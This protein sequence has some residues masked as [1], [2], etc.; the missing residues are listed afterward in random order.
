MADTA[1]L[2]A[3]A[4]A[5][6]NRAE[7]ERDEALAEVERLRQ[8]INRE[9]KSKTISVEF[10]TPENGG[11]IYVTAPWATSEKDLARELVSVLNLWIATVQALAESELGKALPETTAGIKLMLDDAQ[12]F[13][14]PVQNPDVQNQ[15]AERPEPDYHEKCCK[16]IRGTGCSDC[17]TTYSNFAPNIITLLAER[18]ERFTPDD[19]YFHPCPPDGVH[20]E[21]M[22]D[23]VIWVRAGEAQFNFMRGTKGRVIWNV[24]A[25][26]ESEVVESA[27]PGDATLGDP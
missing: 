8:H 25:G 24:H 21:R 23:G 9:A 22:D 7:R 19:E 5:G 20:I 13:P 15:L 1:R 3:A 14:P 17:D 12:Q 11:R 2:L 10:P 4:N 27:G 18:P 6:R 26:N 16:C